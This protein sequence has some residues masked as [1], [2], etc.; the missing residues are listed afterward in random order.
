MSAAGRVLRSRAGAAGAALL[1]VLAATSVLAVTAVPPEAFREWGNPASWLSHPRAAAPAWAGL[2]QQERIPEHLLLEGPRAGGSAGATHTETR[3]F[4]FDYEYDGFPSD[5]I[6]GFE[7]SYE[8]SPLLLL[9]LERPDGSSMRIYSAP[10]PFHGEYGAQHVR[11]FSADHAVRKNAAMQA[12]AAP[13]LPGAPAERLLF[14]DGAGGPLAGRY[15]LVADVH[16]AAGGIAVSG[17]S[18]VVGGRAFGLMGTDELRRDVATGL[19]LGAPIA[20]FIG[21]SVSISSVAAGLLYGV[22]AGYR[23]GRTDEAMMRL[24]D[25]AYA[26]PALPLLVMLAV[27]VSGSIFVMAGFLALFGWVGV[28]K[29]SRSMALQIRTRGYVDAAALMGHGSGRIIRRHILPQML[30]YA[31][32]SVAIS[33]PAAITTE[34]GLSFLGLVDPS[35]PT[36]GQMLHDADVHGAGSRGMWW[37]IVPPGVMIAVTGLAFVLLGNAIESAT[38]VRSQ[39]LRTRG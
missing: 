37:W 20:L 16:S 10:L 18:L 13:L 30:P 29:V 35:F 15:A 25:V 27:T 14:S 17:E 7:A 39:A 11:V 21:L 9:R 6:Y 32:A 2:I 28:A 3:V 19:L 31:L 24:N 1:L 33:V 4:E 12:P 26:I 5:L 36:W 34:A 8:G 22:Y 38:D 23:G